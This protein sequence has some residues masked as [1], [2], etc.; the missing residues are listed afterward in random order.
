MKELV[1]LVEESQDGGYFAKSAE[2]SIFTQGDNIEELKKNISDA[3]KCHF[4]E[5]EMPKL[6]HLH[7]THEETYAL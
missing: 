6:I 7:I 1:F 5:N 4:D 2:T 3:V